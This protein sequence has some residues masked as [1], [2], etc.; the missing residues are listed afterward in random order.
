VS[1]DESGLVVT[2]SGKPAVQRATFFY[3]L[4][5]PDCYLV[6]ERILQTLPIVAE[7]EP[8]LGRDVC[9]GP[10]LN[11]PRTEARSAELGLQP[12]RWPAVWPPEGEFAALAA[13]YAKRIGRAVPFSLAAFRQVFAGGRDLSDEN[14]VLLAGAA[15]EMH[16]TA[17]LKATTTRS[18]TAALAQ[19]NDRA[20]TAGVRRL[21]AILIRDRLFSGEDAPEQATAFIDPRWSAD[22]SSPSADLRVPE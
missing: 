19:A 20:V 13:A 16:P 18:V 17:L 11:R 6:A 4:G 9:G 1:A 7:W 12:M 15:C 14:T 5:N 8:V 3:D 2:V 10:E 22:P 21:P